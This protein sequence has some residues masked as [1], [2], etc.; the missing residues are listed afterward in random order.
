LTHRITRPFQ[1]GE[2]LRQR[3]GIS[4]IPVKGHPKLRRAHGAAQKYRYQEK[5]ANYH[6]PRLNPRSREST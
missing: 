4:V 2:R 1:G 5:P 6:K 3:P